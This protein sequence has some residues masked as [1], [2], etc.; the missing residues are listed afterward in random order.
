MSYL[1][2]WKKI[3]HFFYLTKQQTFFIPF[4]LYFRPYQAYSFLRFFFGWKTA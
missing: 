1:L 3:Q 2:S 4:F